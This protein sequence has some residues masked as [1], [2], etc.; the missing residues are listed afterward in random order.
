MAL[1]DTTEAS[2][3]QP[4]SKT[5]KEV[6]TSPV[7]L[8]LT[9]SFKALDRLMR[10]SREIW[11]KEPA[12]RMGVVFGLAQSPGGKNWDYLLRSLPLLDGDL[13]ERHPAGA[14]EGGVGER[15]G[16]AGQ[17]VVEKPRLER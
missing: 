15:L 3:L 10:T 6:S 8:E 9:Q 16:E 13:F 12:R 17:Q 11:D 1:R 7:L 14:L 4:W 2:Q 5:N